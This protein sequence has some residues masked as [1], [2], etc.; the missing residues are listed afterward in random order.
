M[1]TSVVDFDHFF[2]P[3]YLRELF[4][5]RLL[6]SKFRGVDGSS[7]Q[8]F[9][10]DIVNSINFISTRVLAGEYTFSRFKEKLILKGPRSYPRAVSVPTIRDALVLRALC[11]Y[12]HTAFPTCITR[13]PH[14]HVASAY[15]AAKASTSQ[16]QFVRIDVKNFYPSIGNPPRK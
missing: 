2:Q 7:A 16:A 14:E 1:P 10:R 3:A 4:Y 12:I 11:D 13:P 15:R 9:E 6:A 5:D 8:V